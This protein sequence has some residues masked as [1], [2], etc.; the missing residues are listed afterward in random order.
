[1]RWKIGADIY[2]YTPDDSFRKNGQIA[3][4]KPERIAFAKRFKNVD[5]SNNLSI[6]GLDEDIQTEVLQ[7]YQVAKEV[8]KV[9]NKGDADLTIE[10]F[11]NSLE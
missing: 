10:D 9:R 5:K 7:T 4:T 1:V 3:L 11:I 8:Q 2:E 6:A